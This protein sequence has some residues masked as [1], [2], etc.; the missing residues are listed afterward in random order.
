MSRIAAS[1]RFHRAEESMLQTMPNKAKRSSISSPEKEKIIQMKISGKSARQ[2]SRETGRGRDTI[3][4]IVREADMPAYV[5]KLREQF[6]AM[7]ELALKSV[8]RKIARDADFAYQFLLDIGVISRGDTVPI[9]PPVREAQPVSEALRDQL[10]AAMSE[11]DKIK[12]RLLQMAES[13]ATAY[14]LPRESIEFI[15]GVERGRPKD[16]LAS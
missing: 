6:Q 11:K 4:K 9:N 5:E 15:P 14:G 3:N 7:G 1:I 13:R 12:F 10:L 8:R 16:D 2:I